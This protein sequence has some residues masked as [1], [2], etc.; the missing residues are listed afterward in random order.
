[1][2]NSYKTNII[3]PSW[4]I[5]FDFLPETQMYSTLLCLKYLI[6]ETWEVHWW[7]KKHTEK[8]CHCWHY[9]KDQINLCIKMEVLMGMRH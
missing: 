5:T 4:F 6:F 1:M 7:G 3:F 8:H 2:R 9:H